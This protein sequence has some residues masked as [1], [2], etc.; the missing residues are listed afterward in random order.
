MLSGTLLENTTEQWI[1]SDNK[2]IRD[3]NFMVVYEEEAQT[4]FYF[5]SILW[6]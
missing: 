3:V 5:V 1:R 4:Q 2:Q 6:S